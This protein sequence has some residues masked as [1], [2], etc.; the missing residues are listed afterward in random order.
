[1]EAVAGVAQNHGQA[2]EVLLR[3][4]N[5]LENRIAVRHVELQWEYGVAMALD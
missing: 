2:A 5:S 3:L 1:M 4:S